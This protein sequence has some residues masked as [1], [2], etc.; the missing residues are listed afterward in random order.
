MVTVTKPSNS[1]GSSRADVKLRFLPLFCNNLHLCHSCWVDRHKCQ[2][3][4][5]HL[6]R[7][8]LLQGQ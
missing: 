5:S 8:Q 1:R 4:A 3:L 6:H 7:H 2:V